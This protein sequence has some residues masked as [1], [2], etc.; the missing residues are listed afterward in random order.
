MEKQ[1]R[2]HRPKHEEKKNKRKQRQNTEK[3]QRRLPTKSRK[4]PERDAV[5]TVVLHLKIKV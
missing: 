5:C 3:H 2:R 4:K 1:L